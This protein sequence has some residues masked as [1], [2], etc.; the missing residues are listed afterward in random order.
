MIRTRC[1]ESSTIMPT[2]R[3]RMMASFCLVKIGPGRP[4]VL[5][6]SAA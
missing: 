6:L 5:S 3:S 2:G 4:T 1:E